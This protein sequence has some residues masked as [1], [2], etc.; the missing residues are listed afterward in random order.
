MKQKDYKVNVV[1]CDHRSSQAEI[2]SALRDVTASLDRSWE[3]LRKAKKIVIKFNAVWPPERLAFFE[4]TYRELVD[5]RVMLGVLRLLKE[6]TT[7]RLSVVDT[8]LTGDE[9][10]VYFK[11]ML[12]EMGVEFVNGSNQPV[13][14]YEIKEGGLMFNRYLL[15]SHFADADAVVSVAKMKSHKSTGITLCTKN[16]FGVSPLPPAGRPRSY[17]HHMVRLPYCMVD[18]AMIL[19]PCLNI[20]EGLTSQTGNEWGGEG[21][22]TDLLMAGDHVTAT[23]ACGARL[24]NNDPEI[25]WPTPPF[26][27]ERNT[28]LLAANKGFG[29]LDMDKIDFTSDVSVPA[30]AAGVFNSIE[31]D[32]PETIFSWRKT[33]SEQALFY[34]DHRDQLIDQYENEYIFLQRGE[35]VWHGNDLSLLRS[36]RELSGRYKTESL[37]LKFVDREETEQENYSVYEKELDAMTAMEG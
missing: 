10:D 31:T 14:W 13:Q 22:V 36:R 16:F 2:D 21:V 4:D 15:S 23:D 25:D 8:T 9:V 33:A 18:F 34:R 35:V 24:M 12:E 29:T 37:F 26:R 6:K 1:R 28:V 11:P 30:V 20:V 19:K 32:S 17:F 27:R 7:A 3:Q 5:P